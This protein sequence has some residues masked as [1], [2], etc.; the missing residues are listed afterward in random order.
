MSIN[1]TVFRVRPGMTTLRAWGARLWS[2]AHTPFGDGILAAALF[3]A[4]LVT[5]YNVIWDLYRAGLW[6]QP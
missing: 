1:M 5:L 6:R 2:W 3:M 4:I